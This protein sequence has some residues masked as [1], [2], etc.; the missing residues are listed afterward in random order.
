MIDI[1]P[2]FAAV[3]QGLI[4]LT[5]QEKMKLEKDGLDVIHDIHRYSKSGFASI[6]ADDFDRMKWWGVYRQKPKDSGYFMMRL[7]IPGGLLTAAQAA[8]VSEV[9]DRYAHGFC[10]ITTRMT[11]QYHWLRIEDIPAIFE[12]LQTVGIG[13]S[14]ACGDIA[15][16]VVACPVAGI[17]PD[18]IIDGTPQMLEVNAALENN[19]E[20]SNLPRKYKIS[21]SGCCI[22]CAQPDINCVGVFGLRRTVNGVEERGFGIKIGGGLS[23]APK[24]SKLLP[25]F[26]KPEQ[27]WPVVEAVSKIYR[28]NGY[29]HQR[30]RARLKFLIED[31]W[32]EGGK[33][34]GGGEY[35]AEKVEEQLAF[36]LERHT[37]FVV[38]KDQ[39]TDHIGV[40]K[41][42]QSDL[43]WVGI[44]FPGGRIR[45]ANL[46][47]LSALAGKYSRAGE[48]QIRLTNKQ[49]LLLVNIP[50]AALPALKADLDALGLDY[51][52][53]NF[54]KG[55]VSCT[56]IEF[57]NLA[58]AETKNR[59]LELVTQLEE[60]SGWYKDKIRIHFSGCPSSCGQHQIA[61]IGFRG[62]RTK[63]NGEM[64]DAFDAFIGGRLGHN[65]RFNDLLKGKIIAQDVH[66]FIDKLLHVYDGKKQGEET[67]ADFT[68]RV[69]KDEILAALDWK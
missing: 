50:E 48:D 19:R 4:P 18:E 55:C 32:N 2:N 23:S 62:A 12:E 56:G 34:D 11:I 52:P 58:V 59:M 46:A 17:D 60:T 27:V 57:C 26:L 1:Q 68:D 67:F 49:N 38:I 16:N 42:K 44:C 7:R 53:T 13:T 31:W 37:D 64:V 66:L 28:D 5:P 8:K 45:N 22:H 15:R 33:E 69:P 51:Q 35:L 43:Y 36:K 40:H 30:Q 9:G 29:R 6:D 25:V 47:K 3:K 61:D 41:Q 21:I 54:R 10:D 14:G 63:V 39:E 20:Y 65:R 24:L